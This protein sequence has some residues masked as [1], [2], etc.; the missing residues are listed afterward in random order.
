MIVS[1]GKAIYY[2]QF[3][4]SDSESRLSIKLKEKRVYTSSNPVKKNIAVNQ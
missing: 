1:I 3:G 4:E 2:C